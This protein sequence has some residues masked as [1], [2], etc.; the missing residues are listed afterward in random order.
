MKSEFGKGLV[1][2]LVKFSEHFNSSQMDK[3][4]N[5]VFY[6]NQSIEKREKMISDNP[7]PDCNYGSDLKNRVKS[8]LECEYKIHGNFEEG[9][10]SM[11][12]VW[13][14]G[15]TDHLYKIKTPK[16]KEWDEVR[17]LVKELQGKGLNMGHRFIEDAIYKYEAVTEL[18]E[19]TKKI[20]ILIDEKIGLK[21]DWGEF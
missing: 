19:L 3:I 10:S 9:I 20:C 7:P 2:N 12:T 5:V 16:G 1:V 21:P 6:K 15:A 18:W 11:I 13:A 8:F 17:K 4:R 14:N